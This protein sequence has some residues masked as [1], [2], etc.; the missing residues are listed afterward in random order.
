M[1]P[2]DQSLRQ[3]GGSNSRVGY[4]HT[5]PNMSIHEFCYTMNTYRSSIT[6]MNRIAILDVQLLIHP[7]QDIT[8]CTVAIQGLADE[9]EFGYAMVHLYSVSHRRPACLIVNKKK[10]QTRI[11]GLPSWECCEH[12]AL[13]LQRH[14]QL[15]GY[16]LR[17]EASSRTS[18]N[19][20]SR[21]GSERDEVVS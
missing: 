17:R 15:Q 12:V 14:G 16:L 8:W 20:V 21:L 19:M 10:L 9:C 5:D 6:K 7:V 2:N 11:Y 1:R 4:S 13:Q 3:R 18:K